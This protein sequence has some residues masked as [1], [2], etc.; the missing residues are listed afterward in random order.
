MAVNQE[1]RATPRFK[2]DWPV[3][4]RRKT[5]GKPLAG[6]GRNLSRG[7]A[8][9]A[10]PLSVPVQPGHKLEMRFPPRKHSDSDKTIDQPEAKAA[11]VIHVHRGQTILDAVQLIGL[12]FEEE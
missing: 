5:D 4:L 9:V 11:R 6:R 12:A 10:M 1:R 3:S 8:L 2:I 7:G